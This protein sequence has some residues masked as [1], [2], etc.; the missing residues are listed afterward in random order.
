VRF[1]EICLKGKYSGNYLIWPDVTNLSDV[2]GADI[3]PLLEEIVKRGTTE[4]ELKI[5]SPQHLNTT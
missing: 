3:L 2:K 1:F 5:K 4:I